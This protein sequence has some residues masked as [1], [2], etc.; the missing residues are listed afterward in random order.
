MEM[1][2]RASDSLLSE[3]G[4][5]FRWEFVSDRCFYLALAAAPFS[6]LIL[7]WGFPSWSRGM[8]VQL[9]S[10]LSLVLWQPLV[11]ELLFRGIIQGQLLKLSWA[12]ATILLSVA[13]LATSLLFVL[14][15]LAFHSP[16]WAAAVW[17][18]SLVFGYFRDRTGH[19]LPSLVLHSAY[20]A[21]YLFVGAG[22]ESM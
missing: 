14:A 10:V 2:M 20:N 19:I 17:V 5:Q 8:H 11:E 18:P 3:L 21:L 1:T 12:R 6:L 7:T 22:L 13:N 9:F 16:A 4:L 15:H